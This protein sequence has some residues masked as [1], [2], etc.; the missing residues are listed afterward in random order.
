MPEP[1]SGLAPA[2]PPI[3]A[4]A[5]AAPAPRADLPDDEA[6]ARLRALGYVGGAEPSQAPAN[7]GGSTRTAGSYGNEG[8]ILEEMGRGE[9]ARKAYERALEVDPGHAASLWNLT[10][11]TGDETILRRALAAGSPDALQAVLARAKARLQAGE[12][13]RALEDLR[14]VEA[15]QPSSP[16]PP[17]AAALA[18]LCLDDKTGAAQ[19]LRRSL[20]LDPDQPAL[21][22]MIESLSHEL[23]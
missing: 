8:L 5:A 1:L 9:E 16:V 10:R 3:Q 2:G 18:L 20:A 15:A 7:A 17:A 6:I 19:A 11:L 12:C 21:R 13:R 14:A 4:P 23:R 22:E